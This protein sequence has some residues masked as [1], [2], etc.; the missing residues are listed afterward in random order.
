VWPSASAP[1]H[2]YL[3]RLYVRGI[4]AFASKFYPATLPTSLSGAWSFGAPQPVQPLADGD[5]G[6]DEA[7]R[8]LHMDFE[9]YT[10][11]G[12]FDDRSNYDMDHAGHRAAVAH[13]RGVVWA[14]GWRAETFDTIDKGIE[15][16]AYRHGRGDQPRVERYGKKYG[17]IGFYTYAGVLEESEQFPRKDRELADV[18]IDPSFPEKPRADGTAS[19]PKAWLTPAI[20]SHE[21]WVCTSTTTLPL[22][23][24]R[25]ETIGE[26]RGPW[27]AVHGHVSAGDRVLGRYAWAF[28]S[29]MVITK[30]HEPHLMAALK[31]GTR[32]WRAHD[33]PS[34]H[35]TFAGEIPWHSKFAA[36]A[37]DGYRENVRVGA[38]TVNVEALA[39]DYAWERDRGEMNQAGSARVPSPAFSTR[40][41][42][43]SIPQSFDQFLLDG[44]RA[45]ITLGGV[46]GL[47]GDVVYVR[48]DLLR[49]YVG[50]RVVVWF[51]FGERELRPYPS[52]LPEWLVD[53]HRRQA[54]AWHV[55]ITETDLKGSRASTSPEKAEDMGAKPL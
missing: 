37:E 34:D 22:S 47:E 44:S 15:E 40:F 19:V 55:V 36:L 4:V 6:A 50:D 3:A 7:G 11:G 29:A 35:Y 2:H 17:W 28:L 45:T 53:A 41:S 24:L 51:A 31:A 5:A 26:H 46:D 16:D 27:I 30:K 21:S 25:R 48:E 54:N 33:V 8:T 39:H 52:S 42:L 20:E 12:L 43:H 10:L 38:Q 23:I 9:N 18:D 13:V 1:T 32:P 49:Q 14:H